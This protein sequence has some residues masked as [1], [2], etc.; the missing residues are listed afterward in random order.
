MQD[1]IGI[2]VTYRFGEQRAYLSWGRT[3]D[4][5]DE[6]PLIAQLRRV[7]PV[8]VDTGEVIHVH[9]CSDLGEVSDFAYFYE[10]LISFAASFEKCQGNPT[11]LKRLAKNDRVYQKT[12][13]LLGK[14]KS[15]LHGPR[16]N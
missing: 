9:I 7:L 15:Q 5:V 8:S 2:I 14:R 3:H 4:A 1:V 12:L 13:Y 16:P 10:G 11:F 6:A